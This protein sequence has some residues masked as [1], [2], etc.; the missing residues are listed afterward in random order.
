MRRPLA[1]RAAAGRSRDQEWLRAPTQGGANLERVP[2]KLMHN[3]ATDS[4]GLPLP[5]PKSDISDFGPLKV[6]NSGKPEFG[7]RGEGGGHRR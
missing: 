7:E 4:V 5:Q 6:P 3:G 2:V 1:T